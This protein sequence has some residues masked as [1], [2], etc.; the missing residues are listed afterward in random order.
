VVGYRPGTEAVGVDVRYRDR[1]RDIEEHIGFADQAVGLDP[2]DPQGT[3][4]QRADSVE[5]ERADVSPG[6]AGLDQIGRAGRTGPVRCNTPVDECLDRLGARPRQGH[7][8]TPDGDIK[9]V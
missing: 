2:L 9:G 3:P 1:A 5:P 8:G 4:E 6:V 7:G